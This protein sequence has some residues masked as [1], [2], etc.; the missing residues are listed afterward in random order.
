MKKPHALIIEDDRD[1]AAL[2]RHVLDIAG[3]QTEI[4]LNGKEA[5]KRLEMVRPDVILLDLHLPGVSGEK[6]LEQ[7][8]SD[9]RL[10]KVPIVVVTAFSEDAYTLPVEPDL[11]LMKPVNL[12]QL[13]TLVQRL[14]ATTGSLQDKPWDLVTHLYN[15]SFFTLRLTYSLERLKQV[16]SIHFGVLFV[17]LHPFSAL[18]ERLDE[19]RVNTFLQ[20]TAARLKMVLRPTDTTAHLGEGFFLILL[21]DVTNPNV[22]VKIS[23]R[24]Q[25]ELSNYLSQVEHGTWLRVYVGVL[26]CEAGYNSA[27][28]ILTDVKLARQ[29]ARHKKEYVLYDREM[30]IDYRKV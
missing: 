20:E 24:L 9:N 10:Q 23:A 22:P 3:Y 2:F 13:S 5:V 21:E 8:R 16:D 26:L 15:R 25:L 6:I 19:N 27:E 11:V 17:D 30:L 18:L 7:I 29:L 12:D 28:E 14:R 1:I 4:I